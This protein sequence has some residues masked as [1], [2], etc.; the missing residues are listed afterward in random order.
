MEKTVRKC[1]TLKQKNVKNIENMLKESRYKNFSQALD[2]AIENCVQ[3]E[4]LDKCGL[5]N[6]PKDI[7]FLNVAKKIMEGVKNGN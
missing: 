2:S 7:T 5:S 4:L 3:S 6:V 1:V